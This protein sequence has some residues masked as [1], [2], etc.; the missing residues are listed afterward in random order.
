MAKVCEIEAV[1]EALLLIGWEPE[2]CQNPASHTLYWTPDH[3][4]Q[5]AQAA[6]NETM[7]RETFRLCDKCAQEIQELFEQFPDP[8]VSIDEP[9]TPF[10]D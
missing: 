5:S 6:R 10:E 2:T 1:R 3:L 7:G 4:R 9:P 8:W